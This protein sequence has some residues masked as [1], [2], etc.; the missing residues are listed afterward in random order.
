MDFSEGIPSDARTLVVV[1]THARQRAR[2]RGAGRRPGGALP[3]QPRCAPA[4]RPADRFP[5][6][7]KEPSTAGDEALVDA[8]A[9]AQI[10][11]L[12]ARYAPEHAGTAAA[13]C[14][15]CCTARASGIR[16]KARGWA[17]SASAASWPTLNALLRGGGAATTFHAHRRRHRRAGQRA[18][19]DHARHRHPAAA[20]RRAPVRRHPGASA[21]PRRAST[22]SGAAYARLRHPAAARRQ[23]ACA[24]AVSS[25]YARCAAASRASIPTRA[26][27]RTSTRTCSA[28]A[29]SS[30][31]AS[32]TSTPS[33][34]RWRDRF[35]DN[36]ILSHDLLEGCYA[37]AGLVSDVQLY[38]DYPSRYAA[39]VRRRHRWI[40]GDWQLLPLAAAVGAAREAASC[41][42]NP[43]SWLSRWKAARQ[44][45]PQPGAGGGDRAAADRL[46]AAAAA[47]GLDARGCCACCCCRR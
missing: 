44:P 41:E 13:T 45:A 33:S 35:P 36:R 22:R 17:T 8:R 47:A 19:R 11:R 31:R 4:F 29:P 2:H 30:A 42:R 9:Y 46:D 1:P 28:K 37:R 24:G 25:R 39:D 32:T 12:N 26:P 5:G 10:E 3:G 18:L 38:E 21:Q 6:C 34:T 27:C 40:R 15:S 16:A 7:A 23:P 20:R 43:L 14:S